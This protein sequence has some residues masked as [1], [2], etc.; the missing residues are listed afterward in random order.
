MTTSKIRGLFFTRFKL[1][2]IEFPRK[3][4]MPLTTFKAV[5]ISIRLKASM[6]VLKSLNGP[7]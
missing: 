1:N 3:L 2:C 7:N 4:L 6:A 5:S